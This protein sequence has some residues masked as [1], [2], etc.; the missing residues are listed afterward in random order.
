MKEFRATAQTSTYHSRQEETLSPGGRFA[1]QEP[2]LTELPGPSWAFDPRGP[3]PPIDGRG[4]GPVLGYRIAGD[5][6][7][8]NGARLDHD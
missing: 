6:E 7:P 4:D 8:L 2:R 5:E 1:Q 3:E